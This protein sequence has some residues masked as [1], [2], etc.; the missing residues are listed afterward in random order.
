[1][2]AY[3]GTSQA[4]MSLSQV[5]DA[6]DLNNDNLIT[7]DD[8]LLLSDKWDSNDVPIKEDL[9]LDGVVDVNDL[10]FFYGNWPGDSGNIPPVL[11]SIE[12]K[13]V[14][15][16]NLLSFTVSASDNDGDELVYK[17]LGLP[18]GAEFSDQSFIWTPEEAGIYSVTFIVSDYKSLDYITVKIIVE[19]ELST[20]K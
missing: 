9:N 12:D 17:A 20:E 10:A 4:S 2:G 6:R 5:G 1:M 7:W 3:G 16:N 18:E 14:T 19:E 11:D 13:H 15:V 8:V